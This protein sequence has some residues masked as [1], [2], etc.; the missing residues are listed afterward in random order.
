MEYLRVNHLIGGPNDGEP[1]PEHMY[2]RGDEFEVFPKTH[3]SPFSRSNTPTDPMP[4]E[5]IRYRKQRYVRPDGM[6]FVL[7]AHA[8][9]SDQ[10]MYHRI[11]SVTW[12]IP[13]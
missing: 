2:D 9:V 13:K 6:K 10:V 11:Q 4:I 12:H 5:R 8:D 1:V 7:F 3:S